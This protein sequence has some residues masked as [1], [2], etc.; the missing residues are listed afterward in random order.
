MKQPPNRPLLCDFESEEEI[1]SNPRALFE[2][3][4]RL[5]RSSLLTRSA[6]A[7]D[8]SPWTSSLVCRT[9]LVEGAARMCEF[10]ASLPSNEVATQGQ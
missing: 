5:A 8:S 7:Q 3:S 10:G 1:A 6:A 4:P 2:K 9:P